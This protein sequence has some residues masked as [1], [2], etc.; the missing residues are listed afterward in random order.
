MIIMIVGV[1]DDLH[2]IKASH[3]LYMQIVVGFIIFQFNQVQ[4]VDFGQLILEGTTL[5]LRNFSLPLTILS[6]VGVINAFN[7]LDGIDGL[8]GTVS[9]IIISVLALSALSVGDISSFQLLG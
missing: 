8:A 9:L 1:L 4:I 5:E 2:D 7:M 6:V 3:R